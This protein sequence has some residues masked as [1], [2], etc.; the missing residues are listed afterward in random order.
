MADVK[1]MASVMQDETVGRRAVQTAI[2]VLNRSGL[3]GAA[4]AVD[5]ERVDLEQFE[6]VLEQARKA[7]Y[8]TLAAGYRERALET[9]AD[10]AGVL[11]AVDVLMMTAVQT[12]LAGKT[13]LAIQPYSQSSYTWLA[14]STVMALGQSRQERIFQEAGW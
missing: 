2:N 3:K 7:V 4:A 9:R 5:W 8:S 13:A 6:E 10:L 1:R 12:W 11:N 14:V